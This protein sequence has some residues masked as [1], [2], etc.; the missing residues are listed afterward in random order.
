[1]SADYRKG[2]GVTQES[3]GEPLRRDVPDKDGHCGQQKWSNERET[4]PPICVLSFL[5]ICIPCLLFLF[6]CT[7]GLREAKGLA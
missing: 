5:L 7:G 1:M 3:T 6:P 4:V 2:Q